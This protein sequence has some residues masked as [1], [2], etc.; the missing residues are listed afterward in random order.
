MLTCLLA[1]LGLV[2]SPTRELALQTHKFCQE[3]SHFVNPPLRF[4]LVVGGDA[5][6]EQFNVLSHNPDVIVGTPGRL[7]HILVDAQLSLSR[8]EYVGLLLT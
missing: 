1:Y 5:V 3:L 6:E 7:Q 2:L 4:A 8:V